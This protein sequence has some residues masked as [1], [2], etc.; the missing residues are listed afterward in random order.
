MEEQI[1]KFFEPRGSDDLRDL[2]IQMQRIK[3]ILEYLKDYHPVVFEQAIRRAN[4][5]K[6]I[7]R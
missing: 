1:K 7:L 2:G 5:N 3:I 6:E 4:T